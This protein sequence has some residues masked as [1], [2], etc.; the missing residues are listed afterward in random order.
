[1]KKFRPVLIGLAGAV[2]MLSLYLGVLTIVE[3]A[4][5]AF[6]QFS[7]MWYWILLLSGGFG[8]Q[9]GLHAHLKAALREKQACATT[10]VA[11]SGGVSTVAMVACCAHHVAE[12]LPFL[13][14]SAAAVFL[15][16]YQTAFILLGVF[17]NLVGVTMMLRI[18]Q[19]HG[20]ELKSG[21]LKA[22]FAL[23][24]KRVFTA[25][26]VS[27]IVAVAA[28]FALTGMGAADPAPQVAELKVFDLDAKESDRNRVVVE[29][30]PVDFTLGQPARFSVSLNTHSVALDFDIQKIAVLADDKGNTFAPTAWDG[31]PAGG[32]HRSGT[33]TFPALGSET[34]SIKLTLKGIAQVPERVFEWSLR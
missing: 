20:V 10:G 3:T 14:L 18:M 9:L 2:A 1:M 31:S 23:D 12:I 33:L 17:S 4:S 32:H 11:A 29:V 34:Q 5:Y 19:K 21:P 26:T 22:L 8:L 15:V 13:G 30:E 6:Y 16:D 24:M 28:S 27:S 7:R 25:V